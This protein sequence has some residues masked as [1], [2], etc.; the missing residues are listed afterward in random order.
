[1]LLMKTRIRNVGPSTRMQVSIL[2]RNLQMI[3]FV[4]FSMMRRKMKTQL[5][6]LRKNI[7]ASGN[8]IK[9]PKKQVEDAS[10]NTK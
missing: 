5:Q 3:L 7:D 10:V 6:I 1:M 8:P 4:L 2:Q 9:N